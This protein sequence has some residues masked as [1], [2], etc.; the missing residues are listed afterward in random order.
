MANAKAKRFETEFKIARLRKNLTQERAAKMLGVKTD[1]ICRWE[2]DYTR[3]SVPKF[4][5]YCRCLGLDPGEI[6]RLGV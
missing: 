6:I 5:A 3:M 2:K 1:T 4:I